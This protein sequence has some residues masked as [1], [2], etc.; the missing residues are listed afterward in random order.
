MRYL[1]YKIIIVCALLFLPLAGLAQTIDPAQTVSNLAQKF[2]A[3][4]DIPGL[5]VALY[6]HGHTYFYNYGVTDRSTQQPVTSDTIF[7]IG[8]LTKTFTATLIAEQIL[9]HKMN[10]TDPVVNYLPAS[11]KTQNGAINQV[12]LGELATHM[13]GLP[14]IP[15][16][17]TLA[18]RASFTETD[19][20]NYV[21]QW[22]PDAPI[23]SEFNYS[24][25]G[26]GLLGYALAGEAGQPFATLL[27]QKILTPLGMA[28][29]SIDYA[30]DQSRYATGYDANGQQTMYWPKSAWA[31]GGAMRSTAHDMMKYLEANLGIQSANTSPQLLR[32][33]QL[34]QKPLVSFD[35]F[36]QGMAWVIKNGVI[37]KGG[38]TAG[39]SSGI[40][41]MPNEKMGVVI[42][43]NKAKA[44]PVQLATQILQQLA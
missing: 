31:A 42:L 24:N 33:M 8:S 11:V 44:R 20:M 34:A 16:G 35:T 13:S 36:Q 28:S 12:T 7:E 37:N 1:W 17:L 14:R 43:T 40:A 15:R 2:I 27:Q 21:A 6:Y 19:L 18:Q 4:K 23:G 5:A 39:F 38:L 30:V 25:I 26:F 3:E 10:L 22:Q 41:L 9:N 32:A 29:T